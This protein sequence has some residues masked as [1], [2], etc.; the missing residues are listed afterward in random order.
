M[1][2]HPLDVT[3]EPEEEV[4]PLFC[5]CCSEATDSPTYTHDW[6]LV[7]H[8]CYVMLNSVEGGVED[9]D[10][11]GMPF[12]REPYEPGEDECNGREGA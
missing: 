4:E 1:R 9:E 10:S 12:I 7:C 3:H 8:E 6:R 5:E 11:D 2:E